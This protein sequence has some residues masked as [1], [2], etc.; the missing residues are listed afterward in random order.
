MSIGV[1]CPD[2]TIDV[3]DGGIVTG[4]VGFVMVED[5]DGER[6]HVQMCATDGLS[7]VVLRGLLEVGRDMVI[8]EQ[9]EPQ[10]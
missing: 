1:A 9:N 6:T 8:A 10:S 7:G 4:M 3:E 5:P 2:V